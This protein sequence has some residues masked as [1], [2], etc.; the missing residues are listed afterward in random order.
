MIPR[1][2]F[3]RLHFVGVGGAG[4]APLAAWFAARGFAVS[5]SDRADSPNLAWLRGCG[6]EVHVGHSPSNVEEADLVIRT[7]AVGT[8]NVEIAR[9]LELG[10]PVVRRAE[11][12]G[13]VTREGHSLCVA[14]THG[15]TTTTLMIAR[16]LRCAGLR[17][18]VLPGGV[19]S[20]PEDEPDP[21]ADGPLVVESDEFDRTFLA[22]H[23]DAAIVTNLE[24]DHLDCY[25]DIDD[26]HATFAAFLARLPFHGYALLC[27]EDAGARGL[28]KELG[29]RAFTYAL[30]P[31]AH[32]DYLGSETADGAI[33]VSFRGKELCTFRLGIPGRHNRL[34]AL[35]AVALCHQER[36]DP[37]LAALALEGFQGARRRLDLVG[38]V[39]GCPVYDDYGHHPTEIAAT[40]Q[41]AREL[42]EGRKIAV[43]F[44]PHLYSRT[45]HFAAG[46]A[47]ALAKADAAF[48]APVY[49]AR[50]TP[51]Q[52]A[53]AKAITG[54]APTDS[55]LHLVADRA[56]AVSRM[57]SLSKQGDWL[58]LFVGAGDVGSWARDLLAE[59]A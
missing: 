24:E 49:A 14:G 57:R 37:A 42:G 56:D 17:P 30:D 50:E 39:D 10:I 1:H 52:G 45:K 53:D 44:Q 16:I 54:S 27:G 28:G 58:L 40:L 5:G 21:A 9:A 36:I 46:F 43:V 41:A 51:D 23:P 33:C 47:F 3:R 26:L 25:N 8:E 35:A 55:V 32:T 13:E 48:V 15:K 2:R 59:G 6:L 4:M 31:N 7:S 20:N 22:L 18:S 34:N 38:E 19:P 12:L 29:S 11:A